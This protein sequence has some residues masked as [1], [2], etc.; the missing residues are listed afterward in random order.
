M[1][2]RFGAHAEL[3]LVKES[4]RVAPKPAGLTFEEAAAVPDGALP[5]LTALRNSNRSKESPSS[6][7]APRGHWGRRRFS[8]PS[9]SALT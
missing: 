2:Y 6:C 9:T 7:T 4:G 8:S 3:V 5:A 1:R